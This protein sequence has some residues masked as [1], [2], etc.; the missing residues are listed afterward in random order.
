MKDLSRDAQKLLH[1]MLEKWVEREGLDKA[2]R[3]KRRAIAGA[4]ALVEKGYLVIRHHRTPDGYAY[5]I[6]LADGL[7][8]DSMLDEFAADLTRQ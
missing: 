3:S 4:K 5:S 6:E 7:A 8:R 1:H 2:L